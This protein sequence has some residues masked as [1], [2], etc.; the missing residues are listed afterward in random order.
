LCLPYRTKRY[1]LTAVEHE[2][3]I[4]YARCYRNKTSLSAFDFLPRL[5]A[6]VDGKIAALLSNNGSDAKYF[7]EALRRLKITYLYTRIKTPKDNSVN[8]RFNRTVQ[9]EFMEVDEYFE[10]L[11]T[12]SDLSQANQRL[13]EWLIF[14]N[15]ER[16]H[17]SLDYLSPMEY[18]HYKF[19]D[20]K[21]LPMSPTLTTY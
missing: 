20:N 3:K 21:V 13:T 2:K 5:Q 8:E 18:Y 7:E 15:F 19:V 4:A 1:I 6:L 9:E 11:L 10:P 16:P 14:Y 17:Q 12:K